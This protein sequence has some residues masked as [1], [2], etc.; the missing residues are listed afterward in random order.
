[1]TAPGFQILSNTEATTSRKQY[2]TYTSFALPTALLLIDLLSTSDIRLHLS[3]LSLQ[4]RTFSQAHN[5]FDGHTFEQRPLKRAPSLEDASEEGGAFQDLLGI[6]PAHTH[7]VSLRRCLH[8]CTQRWMG[9]RTK[10][11]TLK[12]KGSMLSIP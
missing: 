12:L 4:L 7:T 1:M 6:E 2:R 5:P 8:C 9:P 11:K 10:H 3:T